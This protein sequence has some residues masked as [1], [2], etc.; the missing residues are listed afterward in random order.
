METLI[1]ILALIAAA[2]G[3]LLIILNFIKI[4][5]E[6]ATTTTLNLIKR[7]QDAMTTLGYKREDIE[8]VIRWMGCKIMPPSIER[9]KKGGEK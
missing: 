2:V 1:D 9:P 5:T 6:I 8:Q 7:M 3:L 4:T